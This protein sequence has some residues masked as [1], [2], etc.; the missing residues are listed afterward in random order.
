MTSAIKQ[1]QHTVHKSFSLGKPL[2]NKNP[3]T[4]K[5]LVIHLV[6]EMTENSSKS[7]S[8]PNKVKPQLQKINNS[9]FTK[10]IIFQKNIVEGFLPQ[11]P[12]NLSLTAR[13]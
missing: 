13:L 5:T 9:N 1:H 6:N 2:K 7:S 8:N 3:K 4:P 11:L 12:G 10:I